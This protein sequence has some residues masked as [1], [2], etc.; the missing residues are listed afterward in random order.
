MTLS[1]CH[2]EPVRYEMSSYSTRFAGALVMIEA[3][4]LADW[5]L[6]RRRGKAVASKTSRRRANPVGSASLRAASERPA[7][8]QSARPIKRPLYKHGSEFIPHH[9]IPLVTHSA[10]LSPHRLPT[11]LDYL[12]FLRNK[13]AISMST[14]DWD[15]KLVIGQKA[16]APKVTRKETDLNGTPLASFCAAKKTCADMAVC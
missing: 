2:T 6:V 1:L 13:T 3:A 11:P 5:G 14:A 15:S 16:K 8:T 7:M 9:R 10:T 12:P 4:S